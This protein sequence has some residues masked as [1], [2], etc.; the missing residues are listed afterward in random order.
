[1][2]NK[3]KNWIRNIY[4]LETVFMR[5]GQ[6]SLHSNEALDVFRNW[7]ALRVSQR[8]RQ[9]L[10]IYAAELFSNKKREAAEG[11]AL[12]LDHHETDF[13]KGT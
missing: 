9:R 1:M 7:A 13:W 10:P 8:I 2:Y 4:L 6:N 11:E 12:L 3:H 5:I